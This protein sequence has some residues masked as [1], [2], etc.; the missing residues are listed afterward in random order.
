MTN[1]SVHCTWPHECGSEEGIA[2]A[3]PNWEFH[4]SVANVRRQKRSQET[5]NHSNDAKCQ[6]C[7]NAEQ[8]RLKW[9]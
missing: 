1:A 3:G 8:L 7:Q 4:T 5:G 2:I 9:L 6:K